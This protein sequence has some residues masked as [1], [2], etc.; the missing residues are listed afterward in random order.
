MSSKILELAPRVSKLWAI[1]LVPVR[2][3]A[4][5][6]SSTFR[7]TD[8][9]V[10]R[11]VADLWGQS[12]DTP[13][14]ALQKPRRWPATGKNGMTTRKRPINVLLVVENYRACGRSIGSGS[15]IRRRAMRNSEAR[16]IPNTARHARP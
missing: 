8:I 3:R 6:R 7:N 12:F 16:G 2:A 9:F 11:W 10:G 5:G 14:E 13:L 15:R 4:R 1:F